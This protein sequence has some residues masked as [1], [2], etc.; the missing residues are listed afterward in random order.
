MK[1]RLQHERLRRDRKAVS[2]AISTVI[3]TAALVTLVLVAVAYANNYLNVQMAGSEF[4]G[5]EQFMLSTGLQIDA[6]AWT[7][8]A[9]QTV[10]YTARYAQVTFVPAILNYTFETSTNNGL[11]WQPV[12]NSTIATGIIL[13]N[14]PVASYNLGRNYFERIFPASNGSILQQ[15]A[16]APVSQVFATEK[17]PM[18][19][20]SYARIVTVPVVRLLNFTLAVGTQNQTYC[21]L[22]LPTLVSG[23]SPH[24]SQSITLKGTSLTKATASGAITNVRINATSLASISNPPGF[25]L[26]F[27]NFDHTVGNSTDVAHSFAS[28]VFNMPSGSVWSLVEI[29]TGTVAV[30]MGLTM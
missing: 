6:V 24:I 11:S 21:K 29:Y 16:S 4:S 22:Y 5:D 20:G 3:M 30:S 1:F 26:S 10:Q 18:A 23:L 19:D 15:G 2:P 9:T 13:L 27:F 28:E 7:I 17:L 25:N 14:I 12:P 8:G